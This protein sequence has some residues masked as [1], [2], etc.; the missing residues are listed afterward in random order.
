MTQEKLNQV[1][2]TLNLLDSMVSGGEKHSSQSNEEK[3]KALKV[4]D[5]IESTNLWIS[6]SQQ[7]PPKDQAVIFG[8]SDSGDTEESIYGIAMP[9]KYFHDNYDYWTYKPTP[10][11]K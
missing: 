7:E 3:D 11:K 6:L 10:P 4:L 1:R 2:S 9:P 8:D 5:E